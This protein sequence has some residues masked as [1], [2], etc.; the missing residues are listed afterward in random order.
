MSSKEVDKIFDI[1]ENAL[2]RK[3]WHISKDAELSVRIYDPNL[4]E[5]VD[6]DTNEFAGTFTAIQPSDNDLGSKDPT[7]VKIT[8]VF[9][10]IKA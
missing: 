4:R 7:D 6:S 3:G 1:L 2:D 10:G 8:G 9:Y 5:N